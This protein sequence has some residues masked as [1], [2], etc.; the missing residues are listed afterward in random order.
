MK[1]TSTRL[2]PFY[3]RESRRVNA[4]SV[5]GVGG[6]VRNKT[7][8]RRHRDRRPDPFR[9]VSFAGQGDHFTTMSC[10]RR[11]ELVGSAGDLGIGASGRT[12]LRGMARFAPMSLRR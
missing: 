2:P 7:L 9:A 11:R 5:G 8:P 12:I 3:Q 1:G 10:T 4:G 6:H